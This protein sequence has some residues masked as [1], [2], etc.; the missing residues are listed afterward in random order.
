M[1]TFQLILLN[2]ILVGGCALVAYLTS[3]GGKSKKDKNL[4]HNH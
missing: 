2:D 3:Y 4:K 1:T